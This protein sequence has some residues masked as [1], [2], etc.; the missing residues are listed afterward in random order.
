M[1]R[2]NLWREGEENRYCRLM[3]THG[4]RVVRASESRLSVASTFGAGDVLLVSGHGMDGQ[5][6]LS[7]AVRASGASALWNLEG[8]SSFMENLLFGNLS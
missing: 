6:V 5:H 1:Q 3:Q 4:T 8:D 7:V 2:W